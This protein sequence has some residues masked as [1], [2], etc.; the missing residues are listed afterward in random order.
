MQNEGP[1]EAASASRKQLTAFLRRRRKVRGLA[2]SDIATLLGVSAGWYRAFESG[3]SRR[4]FSANFVRTLANVLQCSHEDRERLF[5]LVLASDLGGREIE[6]ERSG[7]RWRSLAASVAEA[8]REIID[9]PSLTI[10]CWRAADAICVEFAQFHPACVVYLAK[11]GALVVSTYSGPYAP[12]RPL[13][14]KTAVADVPLEWRS[15]PA[16]P[17]VLSDGESGERTV[18]ILPLLAGNRFLGLIRI[19]ADRDGSLM[20]TIAAAVQV[21]ADQLAATIGRR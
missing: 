7:I 11:R 15:A 16:R 9:A 21:I 20:S 2:Q 14:V 3:K 8:T 13:R 18:I 6:A 12:E 19:E 5:A 4:R 1:A 17:H 10:A